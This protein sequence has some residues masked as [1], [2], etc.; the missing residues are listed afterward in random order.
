MV[1]RTRQSQ[2]GRH[3]VHRNCIVLHHAWI[4]TQ[5]PTFLLICYGLVLVVKGSPQG[6][7]ELVFD[8]LLILDVTDRKFGI[9]LARIG[10]IKWQFLRVLE[11][12]RPEI[13][14]KVIIWVW[15]TIWHLNSQPW[16]VKPTSKLYCLFTPI[17]V[18]YCDS[19]LLTHF[20]LH[21]PFLQ[22]CRW[23]YQLYRYLED[24]II[25]ET[26]GSLGDSACRWKQCRWRVG[27]CLYQFEWLVFWILT[28]DCDVEGQ[29]GLKGVL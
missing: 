19:T 24:R 13:Y 8:W 9:H 3:I 23:C 14:H 26:E 27:L 18:W 28:H 21:G 22:I 10:Q 17:R 16:T 5:S 6:L 11:M 12:D 4:S 7:F 25:S 15:E 29:I 2:S 20:L 1:L